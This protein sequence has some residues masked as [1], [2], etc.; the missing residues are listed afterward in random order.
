MKLIRVFAAVAGLLLS[1][2][3]G[4]AVNVNTASAEEMAAALNGVG[5]AIANRIVEERD[6]NGAYADAAE[7]QERV[8]GIGP[9]LVEKNAG[10]L[11]F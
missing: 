10:E 7:L 3:A 11:A 5:E 6:A 8:K 4:A 1:A 2:I 9:A